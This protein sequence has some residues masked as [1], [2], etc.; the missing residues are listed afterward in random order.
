MYDVQ[1]EISEHY[2]RLIESKISS[3]KRSFTPVRKLKVAT[4]PDL[5]GHP[6]PER[7]RSVGEL[8]PHEHP[9]ISQCTV[10]PLVKPVGWAVKTPKNTLD[11]ALTRPQLEVLGAMVWGKIICDGSTKTIDLNATS[12]NNFASKTPINDHKK[13]LSEWVKFIE[14]RLAPEIIDNINRVTSAC[15]NDLGLTEKKMGQLICG[16]K[17]GR[18]QLGIFEGYFKGVTQQILENDKNYF[19][20]HGVGGVYL[21]RKIISK[22]LI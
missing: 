8:V 11:K 17:D 15:T 12:S 7:L 14:S 1:A 5:N 22:Q 13:K 3:G 4:I 21:L 20:L 18:R 19:K 9:N 6:T 16:S 2:I 10:V